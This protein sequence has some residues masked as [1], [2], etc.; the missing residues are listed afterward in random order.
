M[1]SELAVPI[2]ASCLLT[3]FWLVEVAGQRLYKAD[4]KQLDES[5]FDLWEE[6]THE[7]ASRR[8]YIGRQKAYDTYF[9]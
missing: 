7:A 8:P 4:L 1:Q 2:S 6:Q 9:G 3:L 5:F